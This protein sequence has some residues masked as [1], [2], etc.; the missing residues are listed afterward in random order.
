[1]LG[2]GDC[3]Y[4]HVIEE[5]LEESWGFFVDECRD[6]FDTT[7]TNHTT[8]VKLTHPGRTRAT[9]LNSACETANGSLSD[10]AR[11]GPI[12]MRVADALNLEWREVGLLPHKLPH[13]GGVTSLDQS[14]RTF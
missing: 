12:R 14:E 11:A 5:D 10:S 7:S 3:I 9:L 8:D 4:D 1:M 6:W 13:S 2:V